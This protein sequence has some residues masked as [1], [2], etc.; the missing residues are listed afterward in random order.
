MSEEN[1][2]PPA[3][4]NNSEA[5]KYE[6]DVSAAL[7]NFSESLN[8][9]REAMAQLR[10]GVLEVS[11]FNKNVEDISKIVD[12]ITKFNV[13]LRNKNI[14]DKKYEGTME[15]LKNL[16]LH[17]PTVWDDRTLEVMNELL[18]EFDSDT[19]LLTNT[20]DGPVAGNSSKNRD[21]EDDDS[22]NG[23]EDT[24]DLMQHVEDFNIDSISQLSLPEEKLRMS[25]ILDKEP[26]ELIHNVEMKELYSYKEKDEIDFDILDKD[27]DTMS[28][29]E[30][31][32]E[33][34]NCYVKILRELY[35]QKKK[36][37]DQPMKR[38]EPKRRPLNYQPLFDL[39][40]DLDEILDSATISICIKLID[41]GEDPEL[42]ANVVRAL[43]KTK[44][45]TV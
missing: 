35:K 22:D 17:T 40:D 44:E 4:G 33:E 31:E 34:N 30:F 11:S 25:E 12:C 10:K 14:F 2:K 28:L 7:V 26:L 9:L 13:L 29:T 8:D 27:I 45:N 18:M 39:A 15:K 41:Q 21:D 37:L 19:H 20:E 6:D 16:L 36:Q 42:V 5:L 32:M 38:E 24:R 23:D 1:Q 43:F 3:E